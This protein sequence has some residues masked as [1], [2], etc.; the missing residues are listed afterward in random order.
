M[1]SNQSDAEVYQALRSGNLLAL[2]ILYERY[3]EIVYRLA[4]RA[5]KNATDA[6][7]L[8]QDIFLILWR[9][10]KY[11]PQ[12]GSMLSYLTTLTRS[13]AIDRQRKMQA[14]G[15][16]QQRWR[17][18]VPRQHKPDLID[19]ISVKELTVQVR[20]ALAQLPSQYRQV[21]EMAYLDGLTQSQ[22]SQRLQMPIGTVKTYKRKGL[23]EL[24]LILKDI[25]E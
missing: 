9:Q 7:D 4:L 5:L 13:R 11:N 12:R 16:M 6:E 20:A 21:L 14:Q 1:L 19:K 3:G 25:L 23:L 10:G 18:R 15:R 22:I 2:G 24:R 17:R 8:T